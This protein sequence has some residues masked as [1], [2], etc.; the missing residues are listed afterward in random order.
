MSKKK[1]RPQSQPVTPAPASAAPPPASPVPASLP[2]A[3]GIPWHWLGLAVLAGGIFGWAVG[4]GGLSS[5]SGHAVGPANPEPAKPSVL[6][7]LN[8]PP[9]TSPL[10]P[11]Q[12]NTI[13]QLTN[14]TAASASANPAMPPLLTAQNAPAPVPPV[15]AAPTGETLYNGIVLP[16]VWPPKDEFKAGEPMAVPYLSNPPPVIDITAGRQLFVDDFLIDST[17]LKRVWH[18]ATLYSNNPVLKPDQE[19]EK[20][21]GPMAMPFSDGVWLDPMNWISP[22][23][24][25]P[26]EVMDVFSLLE[27]LKPGTNLL[28]NFFGES[29]SAEAKAAIKD[30][31]G[32]DMPAI[33]AMQKLLA[34]EFNRLMAGPLLHEPA[35]YNGVQLSDRAMVLMAQQ[36]QGDKLK[37]LNRWLIEDAFPRELFKM[38]PVFACYYMAGY[39]KGTALA[40]STN[41]LNWEKPDFGVVPGSNIVQPDPRD[42]ATV[43]LDPYDSDPKRRYKMWRSHGEDKKWGLSLHFSD[44]GIHW[45]PRALRTASVGDR[46]TVFW[47]P[48]RHVWVY[49]LRHGWEG[50]RARRYWEVKDL[51]AGPYWKDP[52]EPQMWVGSDRLDPMRDDLKVEPQLYNLDAVAYESL[53]VGLFTVWRGDKNIPAGRPKPNSIWLGFSRDGYHWDR[54]DR[55]PFLDVSEQ[56]GD[57]NW[58]NVQ[59]VAGGFQVVGRNLYF[60]FSGRAGAGAKRDAGG[61]T[62]LAFL[63]RDGFCSMDA[64]PEGGV[65]TTRPVKFNSRFMFINMKT[66]APDGEV[67]IEV[68]HPDGRPIIVSSNDGKKEP[69]Q[70]FSKE[71]S[72]PSNG[73]QTLMGVSWQNGIQDLQKAGLYGRPVK[74]RFHVKNASL[75]SFWVGPGQ[76]GRSMGPVAAGGPNFTAPMDLIGN[77]SYLA[78]P[79]VPRP[80]APPP[81]NTVTAPVA[82]APPTGVPAPA[83]KA[84]LPP[85]AAPKGKPLI[86]VRPVPTPTPAPPK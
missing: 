68:L 35:R 42:S 7:A 53:M 27:R 2:A 46:S 14:R 17:S 55:R 33:E 37:R 71:N 36:P 26:E 6:A 15:L 23:A 70:A 52:A 85:G 44:D 78:F 81:T 16:Q 30:F 41:G 62:G 51:L 1:N 77:K 11:G 20:T 31:K 76:L 34:A 50:A 25:R 59:S 10:T 79:P 48:F 74:L 47:N 32:K 5:K 8:N 75:Y 58:G 60:Y 22:P 57:W 13:F 45:G 39:G 40:V 82:P 72:H 54:P 3:R 80:H 66:N 12:S 73:D 4:N 21:G 83:P 19:W 61:A 65:L 38:Q 49:S 67:R 43:W 64:G 69:F 28:G 24:F 63:R 84:V 56:Q 86:D 29:L 18:S 9:T